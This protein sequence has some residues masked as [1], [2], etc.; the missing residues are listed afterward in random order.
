[1]ALVDQ[2]ED[3]VKNASP[4]GMGRFYACSPVFNLHM[5]KI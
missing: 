3:L 5:V 4:T 2:V 1:M